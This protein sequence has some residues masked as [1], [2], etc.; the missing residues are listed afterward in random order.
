VGRTCFSVALLKSVSSPRT[1]W[2]TVPFASTASGSGQLF[3][4]KWSGH[5]WQSIE[6]LHSDSPLCCQAPRFFHLARVALR[7]ISFFRLSESFT[8]RAFP[9]FDVPNAELQDF[10]D[11][12]FHNL[13]GVLKR[14]GART[15]FACSAKHVAS[16][17]TFHLRFNSK[18]L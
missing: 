14:L 9:P 1:K 18:E 2:K 6:K 3:I 8:A 13:E 11:G 7:A 4:G 5:S 12:F 15:A 10:A 17:L 16:I